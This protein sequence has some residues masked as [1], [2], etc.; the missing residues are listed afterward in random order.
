MPATGGNYGGAG[1][2]VSGTGDSGVADNDDGSKRRELLH[3]AVSV[4]GPVALTIV[5]LISMDIRGDGDFAPGQGAG[6]AS[7]TRRA[8]GLYGAALLAFVILGTLKC[9]GAAAKLGFAVVSLGVCAFMM[10]FAFFSQMAP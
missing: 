10:F 5:F 6:F 9:R 7:G 1:P 3:L 4:A 2:N 8:L